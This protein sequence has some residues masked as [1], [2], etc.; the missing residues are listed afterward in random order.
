MKIDGGLG[1]ESGFD[2]IKESCQQQEELG[3]DGL[4][5]PE[6]A[7]DPFTMLPLMAEATEN[8]ELGTGI[9]VGFARNP[10]DLAY[11]AN[12]IQLLSKG[13]FTLGLGSQIKPHITKRFSMEW[14]KP[15][16]RMREMIL[17]TKAIWNS[18]NTGE[19]LDFRG[20]FYQHT[21][22]TPFFHPGENPYGAS[23][24]GACGGWASYDRGRRRD[25][26]RFLGAR[27]HDG[28]ILKRGNYSCLRERRRE[29]GAEPFRCRN[30]RAALRGNGK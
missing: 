11:S 4:W 15:A 25:V 20:D 10:M 14:S 26:R 3:Y 13:R 12:D 19:K 27:L 5:V 8:V 23:S 21:L 9:V 18:W 7:H 22:M 1:V 24:D 28:E 16:A 29:S 6:T 2:G 17:A 30:L